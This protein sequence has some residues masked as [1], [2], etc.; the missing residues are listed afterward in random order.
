M[1]T[2]TLSDVSGGKVRP[3]V[4]AHIHLMI[5]SEGW[6]VACATPPGRWSRDQQVPGE[7]YQLID[8]VR[9]CRRC[10]ASSRGTL[11]DVPARPLAWGLD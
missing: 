9:D 1:V 6:T 10:V 4:H 8:D 5:A 2:R 3:G 11:G 7:E